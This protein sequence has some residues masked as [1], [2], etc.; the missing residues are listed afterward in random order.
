MSVCLFVSLLVML[1]F[2]GKPKTTGFKGLW[3]AV[4]MARSTIQR[5]R[6]LSV[7]QSATTLKRRIN[8]VIQTDYLCSIQKALVV[9]VR[10]HGSRG[11]TLSDTLR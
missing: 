4:G 9:A 11:V 7:G 5:G 2:T 8:K 3:P 6:L 1:H 10:L